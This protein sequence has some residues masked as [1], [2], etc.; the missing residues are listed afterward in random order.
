MSNLTYEFD[1]R[2]IEIEEADE[3]EEIDETVLQRSLEEVTLKRSSHGIAESSQPSLKQHNIVED[4][5]MR[6]SLEKTEN[7]DSE[8]QATYCPMLA[9]ISNIFK[10]IFGRVGVMLGFLAAL[11]YSAFAG[12]V[13][14]SRPTILF[15]ETDASLYENGELWIGVL[16]ALGSALGIAFIL[17]VF[18]KLSQIGIFIY[19]SILSGG[20]FTT[21]TNAVICTAMGNWT[22]PTSRDWLLATAAGCCYFTAQT[23]IVVALTLESAPTINVMSSVEIVFSFIWQFVFLRVFPL[24][25]SYVGATLLTVATWE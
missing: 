9:W 18:R 20:I 16:L 7:F 13:F 6:V 19:M 11:S 25:T 12:V 21:A 1:N 14:I 3:K 4:D 2:T 23:C 10:L 22:V 17:T 5:S 15:R 8:G 24:W